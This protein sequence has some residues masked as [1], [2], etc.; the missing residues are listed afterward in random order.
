MGP[1]DES[2]EMNPTEVSFAIASRSVGGENDN[3]S[4]ESISTVDC[5]MC[6]TLMFSKFSFVKNKGLA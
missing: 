3:K 2:S 6:D 4:G 1:T 5:V